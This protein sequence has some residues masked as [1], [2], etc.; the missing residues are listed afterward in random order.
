MLTHIKGFVK[1]E[2]PEGLMSS[3]IIFT[4]RFE[5]LPEL[6]RSVFPWFSSNLCGAFAAK[7]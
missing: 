3:M 5:G 4:D 7:C 2:L 1:Q 6:A